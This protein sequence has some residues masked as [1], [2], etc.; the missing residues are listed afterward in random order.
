MPYLLLAAGAVLTFVGWLVP[1][2]FATPTRI[3]VDDMAG[4]PDGDL[5]DIDLC[6]KEAR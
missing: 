2:P 3:D 1:M 6:A 5:D 4:H